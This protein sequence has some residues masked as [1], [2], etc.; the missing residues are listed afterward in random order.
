VRLERERLAAETTSA[1]ASGTS[2]AVASDDDSVF[3]DKKRQKTKATSAPVPRVAGEPT[4]PTIIKDNKEDGKATV[5][6][7]PDVSQLPEPGK[8]PEK[9]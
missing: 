2:S 6:D 8:A 4:E 7:L 5:A 9:K 3:G 1:E